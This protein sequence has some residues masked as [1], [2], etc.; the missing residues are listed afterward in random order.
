MENEKEKFD[1]SGAIKGFAEHYEDGESPVWDIGRPKE[2]FIEIADL[3]V[4]PILDAGCGTGDTSIFFA[5][6]GL[7][8]IGI[9]FVENAILRAKSKIEG[10]NLPVEFLVKDAVALDEWDIKFNTVIDSGLLHAIYDRQK[11]A[12]G[13]KHV[14]LSGG[15]LYVFYFKDDAS[16]PGGGI[17]DNELKRLFADGWKI[18]SIKSVTLDTDEWKMNFAIILRKA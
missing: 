2:P 15:R 10:R 16:S 1:L 8:V 3:V 18:E 7:K 11:Y 12:N 4:E 9:D 6:R 17:S 14:L 13:L 5:S